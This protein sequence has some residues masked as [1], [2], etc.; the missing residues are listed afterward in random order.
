MS[1]ARVSTVGLVGLQGNLIEVEVDISDGLPNYT[2]L[3]LPDTALS[4]SRE[5]VR[6][7]LVNTGESWPNKKVT[8][9]LSPA[10][11]PKSGSS[12]DLPIA[13][14]LLQAQGILPVD[15]QA[16][17]LGELSLGGELRTIR[18]VLPALIAAKR[19]G[20]MRALVP[21][22]NLREGRAVQGI[23]VIGASHLGE[24][25][26]FMRTG[27]FATSAENEAVVEPRAFA[28]DFADVAG[29]LH[30]KR[31]LEI[32]AI[33]GH[34]SLFIGPPG[35]GKTM[36]AERI[37]TILPPLHLDD[38]LEVAALQSING[39]LIAGEISQR[40]PYV[41]PHHSTTSVGMV[42][43]GAHI[44]RPGS[45]SLAHNGVLFI[46]EA[47]ECGRGVLDSLRQPLESGSVTIT[48]SIGSITY[49][50]KFIL[51]LA[52]NPCPCGKF[53][54]RGR[55]CT[56][57]SLS[58]R[59]YLQRISGPLLDRI[60]LRI[61]VDRPTRVE[62]SEIDSGESSAVIRTRVI[63]AR[64]RAKER[65]DG[66]PWQLNSE[67]PAAALRKKY[68]ASKDA[69]A[70][71][72]SELDAERLSARGFHKVLRTSWSVA[73]SNGHQTPSLEDLQSALTMRTAGEVNL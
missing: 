63:E 68:R 25:L 1:L 26:R 38:A 28:V 16:I 41:A 51:V 27:E 35:T 48:R 54:G 55:A 60:D 45:C 24:V 71:L 33:G 21:I 15:D 11:L 29:Q 31:A 8:V 32:A 69:M 67:I 2:L 18:G 20:F 22:G 19:L 58:I 36:L 14:A 59:R 6:S 62:I 3:G 66:E 47:P 42:G 61:F 34:H 13:I 37:P 57:S 56:C 7:A 4:E 43:G 39:T 9:S 30:A 52:A 50:S 64:S 12:F 72:H 49:P 10:W 17:Y 53:S 40:A 5:R 73:D 70:F 44:V 46:D 65:F 23:E